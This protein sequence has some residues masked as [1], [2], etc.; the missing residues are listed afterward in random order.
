MNGNPKLIP[1][2]DP[3]LKALDKVLTDLAKLGL[4]PTAYTQVVGSV[5]K[6]FLDPTTQPPNHIETLVKAIDDL[7][8]EAPYHYTTEL[9]KTHKE[10]KAISQ[11]KVSPLTLLIDLL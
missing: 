5:T 6:Q 9:A 7:Q 8:R 10:L 2:N 1:A 4:T 11:G 3:Q